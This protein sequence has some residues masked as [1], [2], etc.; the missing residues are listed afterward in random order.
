MAEKEE[1]KKR[2]KAGSGSNEHHFN[3]AN[4]QQSMI[5]SDHCLLDICI[6]EMVAIAFRTSFQPLF[7]FSSFSA[8]F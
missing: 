2:L 3:N 8:I 6:V 5:N 7:F 4:I 1:K